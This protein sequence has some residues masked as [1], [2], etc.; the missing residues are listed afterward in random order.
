MSSLLKPKSPF[1][2]GKVGDDISGY[3]QVSLN[4]ISA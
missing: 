3:G 2:W 1:S 4:G